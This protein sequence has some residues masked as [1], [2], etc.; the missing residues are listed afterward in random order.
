MRQG[1]LCALVGGFMLLA[2]GAFAG[3]PADQP[4]GEPEKE[5]TLEEKVQKAHELVNIPK[6]QEKQDA[7]R[8]IHEVGVA[9]FL[10]PVTEDEAKL[11]STIGEVML[12]STTMDGSMTRA[13][14][15][16]YLLKDER[17]KVRDEAIKYI[18]QLAL[19]SDK[20]YVSDL[21]FE[22]YQ[23]AK[24]DP[25]LRLRVALAFCA[26]GTPDPEHKEPDVRPKLDYETS[27][28]RFP[29]LFADPDAA[30]R[31]AVVE[32]L[33]KD[34]RTMQY[35]GIGVLEKDPDAAVRAAVIE[36]YRLA[37]MK[38]AAAVTLAMS[39]L[40]SSHL[41]E[42]QSAVRYC[43][44]MKLDESREP[45]FA[46][47]KRYATYEET[48]KQAAA[49]RGVKCLVVDAAVEREWKAAV[50][51]LIWMAQNDVD[52]QVQARAAWGALT[53]SGQTT[54]RI[55]TTDEPFPKDMVAVEI[56]AMLRAFKA[57][58]ISSHEGK[59]ETPEVKRLE[60][61][62]QIEFSDAV[63]EIARQRLADK[64]I[65]NKRRGLALVMQIGPEEFAKEIT[66]P[67]EFGAIIRTLQVFPRMP[68]DVQENRSLARLCLAVAVTG[69][70]PTMRAGALQ[71]LMVMGSFCDK[72]I[73]LP[74]LAKMRDDTDLEIRNLV[75]QVGNAVNERGYSGAEEQRLEQE[76]R[77]FNAGPSKPEGE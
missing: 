73:F 66:T 43:V 9:N 32:A 7:L 45:M 19:Y 58:V 40:D 10:K 22:M 48:N 26:A 3:E 46:M 12:G 16:T 39:G 52:P 20:P 49:A 38:T 59:G 60:E 77:P 76:K 24:D 64:D 36:R 50:P 56:P 71:L 27:L 41:G 70:E 44:A 5:L 6:Y 54:V 47:A 57:W 68:Q 14:V 4:A 65:A 34:S 23:N 35:S 28:K 25:N 15:A 62:A 63:Y 17:P 18:T 74:A 61:E 8:L 33:P 37:R 13:D 29:T 53:L 2:L 67:Q 72:D 11:L 21:L 69:K 51:D 31:R 42:N 30:I 75:N 55:G 1:F